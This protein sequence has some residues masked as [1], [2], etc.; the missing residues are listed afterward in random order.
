MWY[1]CTFV[2][3]SSKLFE[4]YGRQILNWLSVHPVRASIKWEFTENENSSFK[5]ILPHMEAV[6]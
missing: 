6:N 2:F 1:E 3:L 4:I 5:P